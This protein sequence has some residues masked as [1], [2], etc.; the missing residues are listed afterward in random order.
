[1]RTESEIRI[2][3]KPCEIISYKYCESIL[4]FSRL[5]VGE[6]VTDMDFFFLQGL[7]DWYDRDIANYT[8][9][10]IDDRREKSFTGNSGLTS[11]SKT[12]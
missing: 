4:D 7:R 9:E 2:L 8:F 11:Y 3:G 5:G 12:V 1:M 10:E 6:F